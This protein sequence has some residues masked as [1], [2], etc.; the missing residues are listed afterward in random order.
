MTN[1]YLFREEVQRLEVNFKLL[2]SIMKEDKYTYEYIA[3]AL[4]CSKLFAWQIVHGKR[5]LSYE[6]A[7]LISAIFNMK[8]DELFYDDYM[9]SLNLKGV[10]N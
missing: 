6:K 4:G 10:K 2:K 5:R 7:L 1:Y 3:N 9:D 8:P